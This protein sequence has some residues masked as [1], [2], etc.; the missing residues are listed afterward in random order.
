MVVDHTSQRLR[1]P[2]GNIRKWHIPAQ[3]EDQKRGSVAEAFAP[4]SS[5]STRSLFD[6]L[7]SAGLQREWH[8]EPQCLG[9][10]EV[11]DQRILGRLLD[12]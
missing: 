3:C 8:G 4:G 1:T 11:D 6:Q 5:V 12:R 7:I 10:L 9:G 2:E